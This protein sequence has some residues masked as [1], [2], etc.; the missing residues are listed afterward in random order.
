MNDSRRNVGRHQP[1]NT[2]HIRDGRVI[3]DLMLMGD[4]NAGK[5]SIIGRFVDGVFDNPHYWTGCSFYVKTLWMDNSE[6][7]LRLWEAMGGERFRGPVLS[8]YRHCHCVIIVY[9]VTNRS[10][11]ENIEKIW[12]K[13]VEENG[14]CDLPVIIVGTKCDLPGRQVD[15]VTAKKFSDSLKL[16]FTETSSLTGYGVDRAIMSGVA[17]AMEKI[18]QT[19]SCVREPEYANVS[20]KPDSGCQIT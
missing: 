18:L 10:S 13:N 6:V 3:V 11:F 19:V 15:Y 7:K 1:H 2:V 9:D 8:A 17:L 5:T 12:L 4:Y 20:R 16:P 14:S